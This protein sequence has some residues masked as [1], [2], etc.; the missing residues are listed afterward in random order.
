MS[1]EVAFFLLY[2]GTMLGVVL[3]TFFLSRRE[4]R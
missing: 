1:D 3:L 2:G 4:K